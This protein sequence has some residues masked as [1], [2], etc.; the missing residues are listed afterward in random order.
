MRD[1]IR[2][3]ICCLFLCIVSCSS[4]VELESNTVSSKSVKESMLLEIVPASDALW[5]VESPV[6][7]KQWRTLES[8]ALTIIK[9]SEAMKLGGTG[10]DAR[11]WSRQAEWQ[12]FS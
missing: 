10:P 11:N 1:S 7:D 12:V 5:A 9:V 3:F 8:A 6:S 4:N 2:L